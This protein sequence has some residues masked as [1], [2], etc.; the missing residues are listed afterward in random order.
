MR[1]HLTFWLTISKW[2]HMSLSR[3]SL[4]QLTC[5]FSALKCWYFGFEAQYFADS[6]SAVHK[7]TP[8]N[9]FVLE[10]S[11]QL[12]LPQMQY[13]EIS[14]SLLLATNVNT[15]Q[16]YMHYWIRELS[17]YAYAMCKQNIHSQFHQKC[18]VLEY[19]KTKKNVLQLW[20]YMFILIELSLSIYMEK[21]HA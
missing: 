7:Y 3:I 13:R 17:G 5:D 1:M 18:A 11:T 19:S 20:W 8:L 14:S 12:E 21:T 10:C 16:Q 4:S 15:Q 2:I 6:D 9:K